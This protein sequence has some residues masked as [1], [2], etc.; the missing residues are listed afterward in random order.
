MIAARAQRLRPD[1]SKRARALVHNRDRE[2]D[3][4]VAARAVFEERGFDAASVAEIARRSRVAEGTIYLYSAT[5]RELLQKVVARWYEDLIADALPGLAQA[6]GARARLHYF[7]ERHLQALGENAAI[8]RLL[9]SELRNAADYRGSMLRKLNQRYVSYVLAI[10]REGVEA[11][12]I[13][14]D[15][16]LEIARDLYFGGLEH[17]ALSGASGAGKRAVAVEAFVQLVWRAIARG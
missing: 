12:E 5:K 7:A 2:A 16:P 15:I 4:L 17:M 9:V 10:L 1:R 11:G 14:A 8:G 6:K 13:R 3:I